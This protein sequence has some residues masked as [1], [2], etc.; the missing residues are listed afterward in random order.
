MN[1]RQRYTQKRPNDFNPKDLVPGLSVTVQDG[2]RGFDKAL[3][4]FNKKVQ[5]SGLLRELK[6][7]EFYEKPSARK[8]REKAIARKRWLKTL[9]EANPNRERKF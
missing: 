6:E 5:D 4:I 7:R 8:K 3:R 1:K 2:P 9:A